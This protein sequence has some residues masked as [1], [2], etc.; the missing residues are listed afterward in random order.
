MFK[1][2]KIIDLVLILTIFY[3]VFLTSYWTM[4]HTGEIW[5]QIGFGFVILLAFIACINFL[6]EKFTAKKFWLA[7]FI[8]CLVVFCFYKRDIDMV[9]FFIICF[10][11]IQ[12]DRSRILQSYFT[13]IIMGILFVLSLFLLGILPK[14]NDDGLLSYGFR[15]PNSL[16]F[17]LFVLFGI[18]IVFFHTKKY[19]ILLIFIVLLPFLYFK[20]E[21]HTAAILLTLNYFLY[22]FNPLW[23]KV[24]NLRISKW[25]FLLLPL[26]LTYISI[27][28]GQNYYTYYWMQKL[29]GVFTSRPA[30]WNFYL[31]NFP[32]TKFGVKLP[33]NI[34]FGHG[35]FDGAF[36]TFPIL[37]GY[38]IF[39]IMLILLS[40][41]LFYLSKNKNAFLLS[42]VLVMVIFGFSENAP[43]IN[44]YSPL[45]PLCLAVIVEDK[46]TSQN[47]EKEN[48]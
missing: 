47:T 21:D 13:G 14:V 12:M 23:K 41:G 16:G 2:I 28:I 22:L 43:F 34:N 45:F 8:G 4:S 24:I 10:A 38:V 5:S 31:S 37:N 25:V 19:F 11:S 44:L 9:K 26:F 46:F 40:I 18:F 39:V 32:I 1:K 3:H 20:L 48:K 29:N 42:F 30:L 7:F 33:E 6:G 35:A 17:L 36:V 27:W 15:S